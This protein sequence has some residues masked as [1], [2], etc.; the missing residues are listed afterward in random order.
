MNDS[1]V[2]V[3][4][5][6]KKMAAEAVKQSENLRTAVR[7]I[8]LQALETRELSLT[9]IK[10]VVRSV[11][12][13]VNL[14]AAKAKIDVEKPLRD[15]L[16]GMDDALL[17]SV[18]ASQITLQL[19]TDHG[20]DLKDSLVMVALDELERLEDEFLATVKQAADAANKQVRAQW[21]P[22]LEKMKPGATGTGAEVEAAIKAVTSRT[23]DAMRR[24]RRSALKATTIMTQ[25]FGTLAS[26][27]L[28]GLAEGTRRAGSAAKKGKS[29]RK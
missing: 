27:V 29:S 9:R 19:L 8:T 24:Q 5:V 26:G 16:S 18:E 7:D 15:A 10:E 6:L 2:E 12:E 20:V 22:I 23:Q 21:A 28:V 11:T 1:A 3:D 25:G 14:G 17:K 4:A 13:G